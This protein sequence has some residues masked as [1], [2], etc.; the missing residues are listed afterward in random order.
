MQ[1]IYILGVRILKFRRKGASKNSNFFVRARKHRAENRS[2]YVIHEDSSTEVIYRM[3]CMP[4]LQEQKS[5]T[6]PSR[7][8]CI[9]RGAHDFN[10]TTAIL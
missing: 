8:K 5:V 2:V 6:Q 1:Q 10:V 7:K 9:F 3:Y 4:I